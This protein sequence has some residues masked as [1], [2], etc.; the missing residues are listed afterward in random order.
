M[1]GHVAYADAGMQ[2]S[3]AITRIGDTV[4]PHLRSQWSYYALA[5]T[6]TLLLIAFLRDRRKSRAIAEA[7]A[8]A[9][10]PQVDE[11]MQIYHDYG[12]SDTIG[13]RRGANQVPVGATARADSIAWFERMGEP[14]ER[15][16]IRA[17]SVRIGRHSSNDIVLPDS[18]VHRHHGILAL[19]SRA[20]FELKD[21]G[22]ANGCRVNGV[23]C[24]AR[25]LEDG[26]IIELGEV[27]LKFYSRAIA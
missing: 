24:E 23:R 19:N 4:L 6:V 2:V 9:R 14:A 25:E 17:N 15:I 12:T 8:P 16:D 13:R 26:D 3:D 20:R 18:S 5:V 22:G 27:K 11:L 10:D 7:V 21:L 1:D